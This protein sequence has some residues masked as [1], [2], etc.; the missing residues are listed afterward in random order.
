[1]STMLALQLM[2]LGTSYSYNNH[3]IAASNSQWEMIY[4]CPE[5]MTITTILVRQGTATSPPTF[6]ASI[7]GVDGTGIPDGTIKGSGTAKSDF[8][9]SS[10]NNSTMIALTLDTPYAAVKGEWISIVIAYLSGTIGASNNCSFAISSSNFVST[11]TPYGI[12]NTTGTRTKQ[13]ASP[14]FGLQTSSTTY[15][16]PQSAATTSQYTSAS[17]G[18][19]ERALAFT[20][21][22]TLFPVGTTFQLAGVRVMCSM[23]AS[24]NFNLVLYT[25]TTALQ[26]QAIDMDQDPSPTST[27]VRDFWFSG[28][29]STLSVGTLYRVALQGGTGNLGFH[30]MTQIA[31]GDLDAWPLGQNAYYS[32]RLDLGAW[33]DDSLSRPMVGTLYLTNVTF[34]S[35]SGGILLPNGMSGGFNG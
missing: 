3:S 7:Q 29:L 1:M 24:G 9:P 11:Q 13:T 28:S 31:A 17:G 22:T 26:T 5:D 20:I 30:V 6:R 34:P 2:E 10:G 4:Q 32:R 21:P 23:T 33:T 12:T 8:T 14:V 27:S 25:G 15:G 35:S 18:H 16:L 19:D